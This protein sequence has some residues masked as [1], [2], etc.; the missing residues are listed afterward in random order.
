MKTIWLGRIFS[1]ALSGRNFFYSMV[2]LLRGRQEHFQKNCSH[3]EEGRNEQRFFWVL[4]SF[5]LSHRP[6]RACSFVQASP[7]HQNSSLPHGSTFSSN[8][9]I[10]SCRFA[11]MAVML[12]MGVSTTAQTTNGLSDAEVQGEQLAQEILEQKPAY[13][14]TNTGVLRCIAEKEPPVQAVF[15]A[16][17]NVRPTNWISVYQTII[18]NKNGG[19]METLKIVHDDGRQNFYTIMRSFFVESAPIESGFAPLTWFGTQWVHSLEGDFWP[20]DLGLE[21]FHWPDQKIIKKEFMRGRGCM[22]LESTNPDPGTNGYSRV[23][24]WIDEQSHA[25]VQAEAYDENGRLLKVFDPK[26]VKKVNGQWE[27]Q[28]MEMRNVQTG[29]R[30]WIEFDLKSD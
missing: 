8:A 7:K 17:V 26:T 24:S 6:Q 1:A 27:L 19:K 30:T 9:V 10:S 14:F 4:A 18:T 13:S 12:I 5:S 21:F 3:A 11:T 2:Q 23:D 28:D 22:V 29:S 25:I 16:A 20:V 15:I